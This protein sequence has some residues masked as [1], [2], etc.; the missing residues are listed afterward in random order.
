VDAFTASFG[1][2]IAYE[3]NS[4]RKLILRVWFICNGVPRSTT[5]PPSPALAAVEL[6]GTRQGS[7]I[8]INL[9]IQVEDP[10]YSSIKAKEKIA[11]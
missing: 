8:H 5:S 2:M 4:G 1:S 3:D 10:F 7:R 9:K 11:I 6:I